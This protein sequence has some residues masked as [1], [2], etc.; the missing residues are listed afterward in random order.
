MGR[1]RQPNKV[2]LAK[3][4]QKCR[5][6]PPEPES[7]AGVG[8]APESLRTDAAPIWDLIADAAPEGVLAQAD[9][10]AVGLL[11][12]TLAEMADVRAIIKADGPTVTEDR[13]S[14]PGAYTI[15]KAH[16]LL[17]S[18]LGLQRQA[19]DLLGKFGMTPSG[20]ASLSVANAASVDPLVEYMKERAKPKSG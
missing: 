14:G 18:L 9:R 5:M 13:G 12:T 16:P 15:M 3:G 8:P 6:N 20:R 17:P 4:T 1:P 2:K 19:V 10:V 7:P 11:A